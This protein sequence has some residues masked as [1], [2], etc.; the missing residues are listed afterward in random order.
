[1]DALLTPTEVAE[2]LRVEVRTLH[3][4][5]ARQEGPPAIRMGKFLRYSQSELE[6]WVAQRR[7]ASPR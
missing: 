6:R 1:M 4:W 3:A 5:R 2:R 7:L